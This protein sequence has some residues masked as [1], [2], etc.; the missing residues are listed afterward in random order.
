MRRQVAAI[1]AVSAMACWLTRGGRAWAADTD[2]AD[3]EEA[4]IHHGLELRR[5]GNERA[6]LTELERAYTVRRSPRAAAQLGFVEQALGMWPQAEEHVREALAANGDP[7]MRKNHATAEAALATIRA[8]IGHVQID[9]GVPGAQVT[10]NGRP[11]GLLPL[12]DPVPVSA[13]PV[14][15]EVRATGYA[16]ALKTVNVA[17]GELMRVPFTLQQIARAPLPPAQPPPFQSGSPGS[18]SVAGGSLS[19]GSGPPLLIERADPGRRKR[20]TGIGLVAGGVVAIGG[21][22][23]ASVAAKNKFDAIGA[24][25]AAG[26]PYNESNGNWKGYET[27]AGVLYVVGGA[28]IVGGVV[29]YIAGRPRTEERRPAAV[30]SVALRPVVTSRNAGATVSVRF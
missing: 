28:A 10:V 23:A 24:D 6:A 1:V 20:M 13:G 9:G 14:D 25:A 21:G 29:L 4:R 27:G 15:V 18:P 26:R 19:A 5:Q 22:V 16:P 7:W 11:M 2:D 12:R 3:T 30:T 8:H 17:A